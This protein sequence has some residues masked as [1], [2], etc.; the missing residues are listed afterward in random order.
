[1]TL[2]PN[3]LLEKRDLFKTNGWGPGG[4][5]SGQPI[6]IARTKKPQKV[7]EPTEKPYINLTRFGSNGWGPAV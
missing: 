7:P 4:F 2:P 6:T 5:L 1:M 3:H